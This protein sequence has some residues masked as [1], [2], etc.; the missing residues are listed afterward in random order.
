MTPPDWL[1]HLF[2]SVTEACVCDVK[3]RMSGFSYRWAKP[4]ENGWGIWL[5]QIAP[6]VLEVSGGKKDGTTGFDFMDVDLLALPKCLD[7]VES[8]SYDPDYGGEAHLTLIGKKGKREVVVE[9]YF[10]PFEDDEPSTVL[11]AAL[12]TCVLLIQTL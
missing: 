12:S 3:G 8:F 4:Q 7:E 11:D 6:S 9:V 5:V 10:E 1:D 2:D